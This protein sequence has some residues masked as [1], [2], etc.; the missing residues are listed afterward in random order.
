MRAALWVSEFVARSARDG[1]T[2]LMANTGTVV[3]NPAIDSKLWSPTLRDV[4]PVARNAQQPLAL[5]VN[6]AVPARNVA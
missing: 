6:P 4:A 5:V 1:Y 2:L 3:I